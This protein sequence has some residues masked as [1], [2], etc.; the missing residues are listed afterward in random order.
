MILL[1][2]TGLMNDIGMQ[3]ESQTDVS[4]QIFFLLLL[5]LFGQ[6]V[7]AITYYSQ[8]FLL[9]R[10]TRE[11]NDGNKFWTTKARRVHNKR[12]NR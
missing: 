4:H 7:W 3:R 2:R 8:Q 9:E 1:I 11:N 12:D 10:A 6:F 5:S